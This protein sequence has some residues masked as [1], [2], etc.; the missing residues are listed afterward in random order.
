M[1]ARLISAF[2]IVFAVAMSIA[3]ANDK[4]EKS[5][6]TT[7]AKKASTSCCA[8]MKSASDCSDMEM[9]DCDP[10]DAKADTKSAKKEGAKTQTSSKDKQPK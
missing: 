4:G 5:K 8:S 9:K 6:K 2:A 10:K 1:K 7:E 3:I